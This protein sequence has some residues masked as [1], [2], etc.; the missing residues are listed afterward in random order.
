MR[1][2]YAIICIGV[3]AFCAEVSI[4]S[5]PITKGSLESQTS[6]LGVLH[7]SNTSKVA[8]QT[9]GV[10]EKI[11]FKI[12][13]SVRKNA[14]LAQINGD[15]LQKEIQ[16]KQAKLNQARYIYERQQKELQRYEN[17]LQ[18][19]S[20]SLTQFENIQYEQKSQE[21]NITALTVELESAKVELSKKLI[22]APIS[23][24]I[25][26]KKINIG[27]W[28]E[29]GDAICEILDTTK[30]EV[31]VDVPSSILEYVKNKQEV[32]I[33]IN[34]KNYKGRIYAIIP[35]ADLHTR[36]L[37]V[38][39]SVENDGSFVDGI[40][41]NVLLP[42]GGKIQGNMVPRDSI[43]NYLG[44]P[45]IFVVRDSKAVALNVEILSIQGENA[46]VR[47]NIKSNDMVVYRG[48]DRL[49]NGVAVKESALLNLR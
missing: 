1:L 25:V 18:S 10:V 12:G 22:K 30:A 6:Y 2:V 15:L 37:P 33:S 31:I 5:K 44:I 9:R 4:V 32:S 11:N 35:R 13:D 17:L 23:G 21:S 39:I 16:S 43:V 8:S 24:I 3:F 36:T 49:K 20:V 29:V 19:D 14:N 47:A 45:S 34:K 38:R 48:Q 46:I 26:D 7:F 27:E 41:A 42:N 28:I 40:P